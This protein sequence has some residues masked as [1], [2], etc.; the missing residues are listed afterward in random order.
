M[1]R[2]N[3]D[4][5]DP[6]EFVGKSILVVVLSETFHQIFTLGETVPGQEGLWIVHGKVAGDAP[7]GFWL[8]VSSFTA[9]SGKSADTAASGQPDATYLIRWDQV[10][11][12]RI[13]PTAFT[14]LGRVGFQ[15]PG[16]T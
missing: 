14:K 12:A 2:E 8:T 6:F 3:L 1:Q 5:K 9:P 15:P 13:A 10:V 11:S 7:V 4:V 16:L